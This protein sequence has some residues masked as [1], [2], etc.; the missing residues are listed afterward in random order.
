MGKRIDL[1][2]QKFG[3][4]T[5]M[6]P[7]GV[8]SSGN[9]LWKCKC[10]CGNDY[11]T[12][13][14]HLRKGLTVS[15]GCYRKDYPPAYKHGKHE[16][17]L[18]NIWHGIKQRCCNA[19]NAAYERYGGR[20]IT[21]CDE[22]RDSFETFYNWAIANGY[23]DNLTLDRVDNGSG[24][25]PDNCRWATRKMQQNNMRTNRLITYNGKTQSLKQWAAELGINYRTLH[26]RLQNG[27]SIDT[28]FKS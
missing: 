9:Q 15:C 10:D 7:Y 4:L 5:V 28:A 26:Y 12:E 18:Y 8:N 2:G 16:S 17:R 23:A 21:L 19:K 14:Y 24:Y 1:T 13:S 25:S 22:W 27:W 3:R 11:I 6:E 20:G